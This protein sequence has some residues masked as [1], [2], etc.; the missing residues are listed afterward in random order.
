MARTTKPLSDSAC[1]SAKPKAQQYQVFDGAGLSLLV[2]PN[3]SK[4][5]RYRYTKPHTN[6][7]NMMSLGHYPQVTLQAA[8]DKRR[9]Y[10]Q[11]LTRAIDPAAYTK[12]Q[13]LAANQ[14][15]SL[16]AVARDWWEN[17]RSRWAPKHAQSVITRLEQNIFPVLGNLR[18]DEVSTP[19]LMQTI[20]AVENRGAHD[21]AAR[22]SQQCI[23]IF[24]HAMRYGYIEHN[25]ALPLKGSVTQPKTQHRPALPFD[26]LLELF[27]RL[28]GA[29]IRALTRLALLVTLH[30]FVRS[31]ELR[32]AR[33][34]EI[35]WKRSVWEIPPER[36]PL[37]GV[38]FSER[39]SKMKATHLVPLSPQVLA[40][41][42]QLHQLTGHGELIFPGDH[43][44]H[45]AMSENTVN[46]ALRKLG[47]DTKTEVCGHGFRSMACS[48]LIESGRWSKDA[49]ERQMSHQERNNVRAAYIH[50]AEHMEE[51][52]LMMTWWADYLSLA[53]QGHFM[54]PWEFAN[55]EGAK[56]VRLDRQ[57]Q[58]G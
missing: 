12:E 51:R 44:H 8:R 42:E 14:K 24:H 22:L 15:L 31:S 29:N 26:R 25:P 53:K 16:E 17:T 38:K 32:F 19:A 40:L 55:P 46:N 13:T 33:W 1:A 6:K 52:R 20:R 49:V 23:N 10:E 18:I 11:L 41:F 58:E 36:E 35:D 57:A 21:V 34:P 2:K 27:Q 48:A 56:V 47:Y 9:E 30:T 50:K 43:Y 45:K 7:R 54:T 37:P 39:G 3:G 28:E 4:I 5:W